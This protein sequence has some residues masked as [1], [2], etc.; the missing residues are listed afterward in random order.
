MSKFFFKIGQRFERF[1]FEHRLGRGR[2]TTRLIFG[3]MSFFDRFEDYSNK[4]KVGNYDHYVPQFLLRYFGVESNGGRKGTVYE[5]QFATTSIDEKSI[6]DVGGAVDHDTFKDKTG[7]LSDYIS[8]RLYAERVERR[9]SSVIR[10]LSNTTGDPELTFYE[11]S[12]LAAFMAMQ[13]TR[14]PTFHS[15]IEKF[16]CFLFEKGLLQVSDLANL[17]LIKAKIISNQEKVSVGDMLNFRS[18]LRIDGAKNHVGLI[19]RLIGSEIAEK[20]YRGNLHVLDIPANSGERYVISDNPVVLLD[21]E[22]QEILRFPAWWEINKNDLWIFMPI[23]PTRCLYYTKALRKDGRVENQDKD[24]PTL[25]NFGQYLCATNSVFSDSKSVIELHLKRY[26][27]E[28]SRLK[29]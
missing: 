3:L 24:T 20:I 27:R 14:V 18:L 12:V 6:R 2:Y 8:R 15:A 1:I 5:F 29:N 10:R 21:F 16:L 9:G 26:A 23:S 28:L 25:I 7:K 19:S 17:E 22:R 4:E 11:E 13:L